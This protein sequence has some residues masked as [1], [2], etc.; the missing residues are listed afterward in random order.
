M[1]SGQ[2]LALHYESKQVSFTNTAQPR[3]S[4]PITGNTR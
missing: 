1:M 4:L 2:P 3:Y